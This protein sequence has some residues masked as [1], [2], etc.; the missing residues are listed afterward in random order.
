MYV[1][2]IDERY[3]SFSIKVSSFD[4]LSHSVSVNS[5]QR[6]VLQLACTALVS[7]VLGAIRLVIEFFVS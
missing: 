4:P 2:Y 7:E 1:F 3:E 5:L 6:D